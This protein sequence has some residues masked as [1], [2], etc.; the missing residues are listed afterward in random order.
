MAGQSFVVSVI[1]CFVGH[2]VSLIFSHW[3]SASLTLPQIKTIKHISMYF[4]M[5]P[6]EKY[7]PTGIGYNSQIHKKKGRENRDDLSQTVHNF[8]ELSLI[9]QGSPEGQRPGSFRCQL[10]PV[11]DQGGNQSLGN[12][13]EGGIVGLQKYLHSKLRDIRCSLMWT[14]EFLWQQ[15]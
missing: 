5:S 14:K 1:F 10:L 15:L 2:F 7:C 12:D 9:L 11:I 3:M 4:Q 8:T 6:V 13:V